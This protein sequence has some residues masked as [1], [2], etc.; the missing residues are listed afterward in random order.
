MNSFLI[1]YV[2]A[3]VVLTFMSIDAMSCEKI[4]EDDVGYPSVRSYIRMAIGEKCAFSFNFK[5]GYG[6][7][8]FKGAEPFGLQH[9]DA[10]DVVFDTS[11]PT[12]SK[13]IITAKKAGGHSFSYNERL[14]Y[15]DLQSA[16]W[17]RIYNVTV[18]DQ[19]ATKP[20]EKTNKGTNK[21]SAL[22]NQRIQGVDYLTV[23][24]G[25][26]TASRDKFETSELAKFY[27]Q[28]AKAANLTVD[29]CRSVI[30]SVK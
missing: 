29:Q 26:L 4:K 30:S 10:L 5:T 24:Q 20:I 3:S 14:T 25:A 27:V 13:F 1:K 6:A 7:A 23:C 21:Q 15:F 28:K 18:I 9:T 22:A 2:T 19:P 11:D 16:T 8:N 17:Y 12:I